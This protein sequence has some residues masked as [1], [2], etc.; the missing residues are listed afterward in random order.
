MT[1]HGQTLID[2]YFWLREK[3]NPQV[4]AHLKAENAYAEAM[5][6]PTAALQDALYKEMLGHIKQ[7][8]ETVP[9]LENGYFYY[10]R[11]ERASSIPIYCR[12]RG[13][14]TAAEEVVLDQNE[15]AKGQK[16]LSVGAR[17]VATM[18][19]CWRSRPTPP[20]IGNTRCRSRTCGPASCCPT[21][22][23]RV[24]D[25]AWA[26]DNKTIF[27]VTEDAVTKRHDRFLRHVV[28]ADKSDLV[29]EEK[30]ELFDLECQRSRD[31]A[32]ILLE[33]AAKTST[34]VRYL[35]ADRPTDAL[36]IIAPRQPDHEYDVDHRGNLCYIR[37]NKDAKNFRVVTAP[38]GES[39]AG[40]L[41]RARRRIVP[42]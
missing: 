2:D 35:P 19:I 5:M 17:A 34:E 29:Y 22:I 36:R 31:K 39:V 1:I 25:I 33:A 21:R 4:M 10:S 32:V 12:K 42:T 13:S 7:T 40:A 3:T 15:L 28:G 14:L 24:D 27:Y 16:F 11:T 37:T 38:A 23:E 8:D 20:A 6:K 18:A 30:D 9:Y 41:E 26:T